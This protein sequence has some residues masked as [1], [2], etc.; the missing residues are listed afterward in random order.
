[1]RT[2]YDT[3]DTERCLIRFRW[4]LPRWEAHRPTSPT[5]SKLFCVDYSSVSRVLQT[6]SLTR[7]EHKKIPSR[8]VAPEV[9]EQPV[10]LEP[11][12]CEWTLVEPD[13][14][15]FKRT[16]VGADVGDP[17]LPSTKDSHP[18][19]KRRCEKSSQLPVPAS[20]NT[21][22]RNNRL[23]ANSNEVC[24]PYFQNTRVMPSSQQ[25]KSPSPADAYA[26]LCLLKLYA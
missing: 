17:L 21:I 15:F 7:V 12:R 9:R 8:T 19:S 1:M 5:S 18:T 3:H 16:L 23:P 24:R 10:D 20:T 26:S 4:S 13:L 22:R 6:R 25:A 14:R 11:R 2:R